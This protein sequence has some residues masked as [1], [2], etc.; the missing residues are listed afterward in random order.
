MQLDLD[1]KTAL[2]AVRQAENNRLPQLD[3]GLSGALIGQ[4]ASYGPAVNEIGDADAHAY[5][6]ILNF[7]WTPLMRAT[8]AQTEIS[9]IQH[10]M[11]IVR[12]DQS[13]QDIWFAV[14]DAVRNQAS[15]SRQV[16]AASKFRQLST[17]SLEVEQ[18]KFLSNQSSNFTLGQHQDELAAAQ[19]AE[20]TAVL[21]HKKASAAL[22]KATGMLLD[23]R[24]IALDVNQPPR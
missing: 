16:L 3:L 6:L 2:L 14:R 1:L 17:Q 12:R 9:K 4:Q 18:R 13:I 11:A 21:V 7:Q 10:Q 5:S 15:A 23:E 24:H 20:L 8:T 19:L 22:L